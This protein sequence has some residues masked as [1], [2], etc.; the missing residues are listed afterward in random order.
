MDMDIEYDAAKDALN[1]HKHGVPLALAARFEW[2]MAQIE[3]DTRFDYEE[4]RFKA[5]GISGSAC[6]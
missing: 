6:M 2:D 1:R 5:T 3:E 4:Q